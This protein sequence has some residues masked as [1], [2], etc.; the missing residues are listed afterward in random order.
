MAFET[1]VLPADL[2]IYPEIQD[3]IS[4]TD[5]G[6]FAQNCIDNAID[7]CKS[8]MERYDLNAMFGDGTTSASVSSP[9]LN[10]IV[11]NIATWY[12]LTRASPN[13]DLELARTLYEDSIKILD[14]I[15]KRHLNPSGW[16]Y[17]ETTG[18]P[19]A[20]KGNSIF[21]NPTMNTQN[22]F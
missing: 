19:V 1:I 6:V 9:M 8:H 14:K 22:K 20:P 4:R 2:N 18:Q 11:I 17:L 13:I 3:I 7:L 10:K 5:S 21:F 16:V 15:Q 12:M